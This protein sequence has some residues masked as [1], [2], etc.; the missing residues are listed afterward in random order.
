MTLT[1]GTA[2]A[3]TLMEGKFNQSDYWY[4]ASLWKAR[5][6]I[7]PNVAFFIMVSA[8]NKAHILHMLM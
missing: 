8:K 5:N 3:A 1:K 6:S 7:V 4:K 2:T